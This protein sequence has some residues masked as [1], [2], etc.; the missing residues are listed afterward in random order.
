MTWV[1]L[2]KYS[3]GYSNGVTDFVQN[4]FDNFVVGSELRCPCKDYSNHFWFCQ[5][6]VYDHLVSNSVCPSLSNWI[7]EVSTPKFRTVYEDMDCNSGMG[8]GDDFDN[9]IHDESRGRNGMNADARGFYKLV[10]EGKQPLYP[11][12][13]K[14]THLGFIVKLY[15]LKCP[16]GFTESDFSGI[17]KLI[18]EAFPHVNLPSSFSVLRLMRQQIRI[19][20]HSR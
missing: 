18:K 11:G 15:L 5:E 1:S 20:S 2:P 19:D 8:L 16:H 3:E 7:Y 14:F 10:E 12:C 9:M 13:K 4:A 17:L 6:D